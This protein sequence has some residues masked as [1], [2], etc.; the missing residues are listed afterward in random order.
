MVGKGKNKY[1]KRKPK[2]KKRQYK[3]RE[4]KTRKINIGLKDPGIYFGDEVSR[5][6]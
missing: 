3:I 5:E 1:I 4:V 2:K 6:Y